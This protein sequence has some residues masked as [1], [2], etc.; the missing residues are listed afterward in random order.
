MLYENGRS[1]D[2]LSYLV[3]VRESFAIGRLMDWYTICSSEHCSSGGCNH[4]IKW[5]VVINNDI[6]P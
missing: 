6:G 5:L 4:G 2:V 3:P 1:A